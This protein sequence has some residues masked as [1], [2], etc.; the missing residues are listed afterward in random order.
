MAGFADLLKLRSLATSTQEEYL[1]FLRNLATRIGRDPAELTEAEVRSYV[2]RLKAEFNYAPSSMRVVVGALQMFY[3]RHLG[4]DWRLFGLI[5]SPSRRALPQVLTRSQVAAL[6][7]DMREARFRM[8]FRL[9]Y[10]CGLRVSEAAHLTVDAIEGDGTRL[11]IRAAKGNKDRVVP[12]PAWT[13]AELRVFWKTHRHPRWLFP[14]CGRGWRNQPAERARLARASVPVSIG[15]IQSY[16]RRV[17]A[18]V[19]VPATTCVH[20][21][22]HSYATHLLEEGVSIRLISAFLGHAS[23][24]QP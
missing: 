10:A 4:H 2:L 12:L 19:H 8:I 24:R 20:T 5:R 23:W 1:R 6:F 14:R 7:A 3:N 11:R 13:L 21:L 18:T 22:R 15:S 17:R 9:I 16:L